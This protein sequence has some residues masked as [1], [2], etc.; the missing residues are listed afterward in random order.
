MTESSASSEVADRPLPDPRAEPPLSARGVLQEADRAAWQARR[1]LDASRG[2]LMGNIA[3][4]ICL[5]A[6]H[7]L[8]WEVARDG[9]GSRV[10]GAL[11]MIGF[12][13]WMVV[14]IRWMV[15]LRSSGEVKVVDCIET[16]LSAIREHPIRRLAP[17][18]ALVLG[19]TLAWTYLFKVMSNQGIVI[20]MWTVTAAFAGLFV[21]RFFRFHFWE[22]LL[23][24]ASVTSAWSLY[25]L[26]ARHLAPLAI[27][28]LLA[29][30]VGTVCLHQRWRN[31]VRSLPATEAG[32]LS[33]EDCS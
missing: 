33:P 16:N 15:R 2:I 5:I 14:S 23:F 20:A 21:G 9:D 7:L 6:T 25:L 13:V 4:G 30:I 12:A 8:W 22:D 3:M 17:S 32:P 29:V 24:A 27:V 26:H 18:Y 19:A 10:V 28:P 11:V 1:L 31:W